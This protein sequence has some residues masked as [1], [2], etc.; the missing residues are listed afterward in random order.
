MA[1]IYTRTGDKGDT[2][3]VGGRRISKDDL[4]IRAIGDV[5]ELNAAIGV[6]RAHGSD[7]EVDEIL[8]TVQ[9]DLFGVGAALAGGD[10]FGTP[11]VERIERAIDHF[12]EG[13]PPLREFILPAGSPQAAHLHYA[14]AVCRRA[15]RSV[16][17]VIPRSSHARGILVYL[18]RLSDL[19]FVLART[20]NARSAVQ[21]T[22]WRK[23][24]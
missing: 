16:V 19:L 12:Q 5:D 22:V 15:E 17:A 18:N 23:S 7:G 14:R 4:L 24:E 8:T 21:E 1:R 20:A 6:A 11:P 10:S 13:L 9:N 2:G 3:L